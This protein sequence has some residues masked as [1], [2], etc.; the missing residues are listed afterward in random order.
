M[1]MFSVLVERMALSVRGTRKV[2][3]T[4]SSQNVVLDVDPRLSI[5]PLVYT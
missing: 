4:P 5:I 2:S 1:E 3:S